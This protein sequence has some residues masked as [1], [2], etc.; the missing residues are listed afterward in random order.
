M[1]DFSY[2][3]ECNPGKKNVVAYCLLRLPVSDPIK[4]DD[5]NDESVAEECIVTDGRMSHKEWLKVVK[6]GVTLQEA[7]G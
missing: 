4:N 5:E 6:D 7:V 2:T 3:M 1:L